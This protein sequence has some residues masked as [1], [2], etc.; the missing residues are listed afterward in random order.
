MAMERINQ[1]LGGYLE[2]LARAK[3]EEAASHFGNAQQN[4]LTGNIVGADQESA[5]AHGLLTSPLTTT[6]F[7]S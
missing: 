6:N 2:G 4:S 5:I 3:A 1:S 7:I